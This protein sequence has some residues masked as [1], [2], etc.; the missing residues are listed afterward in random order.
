[1]PAST[2]LRAPGEG[3]DLDLDRVHYPVRSLGPG[4][5]VAL[6]VRGCRLGCPGCM[7][8]ELAIPGRG[9]RVPVHEVA[10]RLAPLAG[11]VDGVTIT[12]GE[13]FDQPAPLAALVRKL[14]T[15][16]LGD[17]LVYSGY[18]LEEIGRQGPAAAEL[19]SLVDILIDGRFREEEPTRKLWRGSANQKLHLLSDLARTRYG[20]LAES[21]YRGRRPLEVGIDTAGRLFIVGIPERGDLERFVAACRR[22]GVVLEEETWDVER[23]TE[24]PALG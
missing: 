15:L 13:P 3:L 22:R 16:G 8:R 18:T 6:W 10:S 14:K 7:S 20:H 5:R 9:P 4:T 21:E 24:L 19:L 2:D 23:P 11:R 12:G 17:V 1:M